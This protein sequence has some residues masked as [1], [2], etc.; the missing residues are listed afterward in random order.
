MKTFKEYFEQQP[1]SRA[2]GEEISKFHMKQAEE[3]AKRYMDRVEQEENA[4]ETVALLA[5]GFKPPHKG[6]LKL[7]NKLLKDADKGVIFIGKKQDREGREWITPDASKAIWEIYTRAGK[8]VE[9]NIA[10]ISP[11]TSSYDFADDNTDKK[12][13]IGS[14]PGD[15]AR[16]S[17]FK[18]KDRYPHVA[19]IPQEKALGGGIRAKDMKKYLEV[20]NIEEAVKRFAP[21]E[22]LNET[23]IDAIT[24]ILQK[25]WNNR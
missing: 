11:V 17:G 8:P 9:V 19:L 21:L 16:N 3:E 10:P 22:D 15:A 6:H 25:D 18:N 4:N 20:G 5:G 7:F 23:D 14:G 12:I 13:I 2:A 1:D 24:N